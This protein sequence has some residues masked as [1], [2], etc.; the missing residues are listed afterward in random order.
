[1]V[2]IG[3]VAFYPE[4]T[5]TTA[6]SAVLTDRCPS[7]PAEDALYAYLEHVFV[8]ALFIREK[9]MG[10][11][12]GEDS[13]QREEEEEEGWFHEEDQTQEKKRANG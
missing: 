9:K 3:G 2:K 10:Q 12:K 8:L 5:C 1:M 6:V 4:P 13:A 7:P 11:E